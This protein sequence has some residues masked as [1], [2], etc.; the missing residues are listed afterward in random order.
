[1]ALKLVKRIAR[2]V[3][4]ALRARDR[5]EMQAMDRL[6]S[7]VESPHRKRRRTKAPRLNGQRRRVTARSPATGP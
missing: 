5:A 4:N 1:M 6:L 7:M 3:T 2:A